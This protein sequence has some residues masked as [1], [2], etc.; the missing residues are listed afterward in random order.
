[1]SLSVGGAALGFYTTGFSIVYDVLTTGLTNLVCDQVALIILVILLILTILTSPWRHGAPPGP[2]V[3]NH[4]PLHHIAP[5][6][7]RHRHL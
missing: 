2:V 1:M 4:H 6:G 3:H 5:G 7:L